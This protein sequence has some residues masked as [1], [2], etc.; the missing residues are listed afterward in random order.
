MSV[1][2]ACPRRAVG[3]APGGIAIFVDEEPMKLIDSLKTLQAVRSDEIVITSMGSA[4]EWQKLQKHPLDFVLVPSSMGQA[5]ALGLGMALA[6]PERKVVVFNGDGSMLMNLGSLVTISANAPKNLV[7]IVVDNGI[8]EVTGGQPTLAAP[9]LREDGSAVDFAAIARSC[10]FRAVWTFD[11]IGEWKAGV[12]Q[13]LEA[14]GPVFVHLR[15]EPM[16][17]AEIL[18]PP[19]PSPERAR[20]FRETLMRP[21]SRKA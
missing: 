18:R 15:V 17:D 9:A 11:A 7:V 19:G 2:F 6:R 21:E 16:M 3:M 1:R 8:Y 14:V 4:R 20:V 5:T 13:V 10:G 12:G